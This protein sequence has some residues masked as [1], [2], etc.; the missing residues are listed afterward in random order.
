MPITIE[1]LAKEHYDAVFRFCSVRVGYHRAGDAAQ[2]TFL[3]AQKNLSKF[4]G[5]SKPLTWLIGIAFN[6]CR[7]VS[8]MHSAEDY[9]PEF[10][11][12]SP[13][14][15]IVDRELLRKAL[16]TLTLE[17]RDVVLLHEIDGFTYEEIAVIVGVPVG[18]VKSRIFHAFSGL[19]KALFIDP[20][21]VSNHGKS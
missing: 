18:T 12:S 11:N 5:D 8:R 20:K 6:E 7:R 15:E 17:H 4:R 14:G 13:E 2:E 1:Q 16:L 19:R 3:T 10:A 9:V 21:E